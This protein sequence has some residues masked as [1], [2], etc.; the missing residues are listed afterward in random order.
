MERGTGLDGFKTQLAKYVEEER[1]SGL[2]G[3]DDW[4]EGTFLSRSSRLV[5]AS[6]GVA[7]LLLAYW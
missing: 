4:M 5:K 6:W 1:S 7:G 2:V 3:K